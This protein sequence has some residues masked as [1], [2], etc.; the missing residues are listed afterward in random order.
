[1]EDRSKLKVLEEEI[2]RLID[3]AF[4]HGIEKDRIKELSVI[5]YD[6][7]LHT[8]RKKRCK[9]KIFSIFA[10]CLLVVVTTYF[11]CCSK[12]GFAFLRLS[13]IK[14]CYIFMIYLQYID[15]YF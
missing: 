11:L 15:L 14:A 9:I 12:I 5:S 1:M 2:S 8:K 10:I 13:L 7:Y 4:D 6:E 3:Y